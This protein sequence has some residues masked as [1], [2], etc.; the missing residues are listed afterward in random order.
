MSYKQLF[1]KLCN[2]VVGLYFW[3]NVY[4]HHSIMYALAIGFVAGCILSSPFYFLS[5]ST[6]SFGS[7]TAFIPS[8]LIGCYSSIGTMLFCNDKSSLLGSIIESDQNSCLKLAIKLGWS[9]SDTIKHNKFD[10]PSHFR[11]YAPLHV[12]V[13]AGNKQA[14]KMLLKAGADINL[15]TNRKEVIE[16]RTKVIRRVISRNSHTHR[17]Y[18]VLR[19]PVYGITKKY[20]PLHLAC[21]AGNESMIQLLLKHHADNT[22]TDHLGRVPKS[23]LSM[24][25]AQKLKQKS[26]LEHSLL[27]LAALKI[28]ATDHIKVTDDNTVYDMQVFLYEVKC[29]EALNRF[30]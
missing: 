10:I 6:L 19:T 2:L 25:C 26:K 5:A 15:L 17:D 28:N 9:R 8:F 27:T 11:G 21:K 3:L 12:A 30:P 13:V 29:K 18:I 23:L 22:Q 20:S 24:E 16:I 7:I 14:A 1:S 4:A